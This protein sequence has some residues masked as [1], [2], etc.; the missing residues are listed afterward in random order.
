M[1]ARYLASLVPELAF[2][3]HKIA[4]VSG[5]RQCGKT[6]MARMLLTQRG[7]GAYFNWDEIKFR[8]SWAK[9]PSSLVPSDEGSVPL[10][11]FD[12]IHKAKGWKRTLKGLFD[13]RQAPWDALVT[14]SARL[15]VYK[16][17]G[18]SLLG[19]SLH[20]RM[21]PFSC[22]EIVGAAADRSP[23]MCLQA[24]INGEAV[25]GAEEALRA[26][27]R[28][29]GFPEPFL[30]A[31]DRRARV[32]RQSRVEKVI[33]EDL[34][35][36]SRLPELDRVEMLAALLPERVGSLLSRASLREDLEVSHDTVT[37]WLS[38]LKE[39]YYAFELRPYSKGLARS[40]KK[41]GKL[42]LWDW[43]EVEAAGPRFENLVACHLLKAC[44]FWTDTGEGVFELTYLR[45]KDKNEV[46]FLVLRGRKPWL[47]VE[48]KLSDVAPSPH[49]QKFL[50]HIKCPFAVQLV[51]APGH[52]RTHQVGS[53]RVLVASAASA[54]AELV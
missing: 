40:L 6:T 33:R 22:A 52:F 29:G 41:E 54:L 16:K 15:N 44:D 9:D 35:D 8:R 4:M 23:D 34:R 3:G 7:H 45:N 21:H 46:D 28:F 37:R 1:R 48:A 51:G 24:L 27:L 31:S 25:S 50:P 14:G 30:S 11:V 19:R 17:G 32:W 47:A 42:Y 5:P 39:L 43:S 26:L 12:E 53:S 18:D 20:F 36:L 49:W 2:A 38:A 10:Y 13:T